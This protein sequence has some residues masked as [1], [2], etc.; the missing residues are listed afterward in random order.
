MA[1]W[2]PDLLVEIDLLPTSEGGRTGL[3]PETWFGCPVA[4]SSEYFDA[5]MDLTAVGSIA[6]GQ[7]VQA[8]LKF[9]SPEL[10]MPRVAVGQVLELWEG[11]TIGHATILAVYARA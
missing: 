6:P 9:L 1:L 10:T 4:I 7:H 5:R 3:T 11:R 8:P 2:K